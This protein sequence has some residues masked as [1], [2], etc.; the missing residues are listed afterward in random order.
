MKDDKNKIKEPYDP[1]HTP[2]PPQDIDPS[3]RKERGERDEPIE[4]RKRDREPG[5]KKQKGKSE[6][7]KP[8]QGKEEESKL[9]G[10]SEKEITGETAT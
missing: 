4:N 3:L 5:E 7:K 10:E 8:G 6:Q 1:A 9:P 2:S